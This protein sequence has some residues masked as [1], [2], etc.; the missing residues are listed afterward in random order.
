MGRRID[1]VADDRIELQEIGAVDEVLPHQVF[2]EGKGRQRDLFGDFP[3]L[4]ALDVTTNGLPDACDVDAGGVLR[5]IAV[6]LWHRQ[7]EVLL[8]HLR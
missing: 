1:Q 6:E 4:D 7:I 3:A 2:C 5:Q 8:K